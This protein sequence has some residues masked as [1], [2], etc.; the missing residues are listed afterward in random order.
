VDVYVMRR[1]HVGLRLMRATSSICLL[2]SC[3]AMFG[4]E[5]GRLYPADAGASGSAGSA[6]A[7]GAGGVDGSALDAGAD[8]KSDAGDA[9]GDVRDASDAAADGCP[10]LGVCGGARACWCNDCV[11]VVEACLEY[12]SCKA[13]LECILHADCAVDLTRC[14][15]AEASCPGYCANFHLNRNQ[16]MGQLL[17]ISDCAKAA[18]PRC[19]ACTYDPS[20]TQFCPLLAPSNGQAV[21]TGCPPGG[22]ECDYG[23]RHCV[24]SGSTWT[25][26]G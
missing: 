14:D 7:G 5:E 17:R 15:G 12:E 16:A 2:A 18:S 1:V 26:T 19:G 21:P 23:A 11:S 25:C 4:I 24:C 3:N 6:G 10:L 8:A 9:S 13:A 22:T 20:C